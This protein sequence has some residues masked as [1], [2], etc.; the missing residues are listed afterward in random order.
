MVTKTVYRQ[1]RGFVIG[2]LLITFIV[3]ALTFLAI[4]FSYS[5]G[6]SAP[7]ASNPLPLAP[8]ATV[9][10]PDATEVPAQVIPSETPLPTL[11]L[12]T[13]PTAPVL[14]EE[15]TDVPTNTPTPIPSPTPTPLPV[16]DDRYQAGIQVE[17]SLDF[18]PVN[19]DNYYRS[20]AEDLG[21][22]WVKHQVRWELMEPAPGEIDWSVLDF[23]MPSAKKF[24]IKMLLSIVTAPHWAREDGVTLERHGPPADAHVYA[25]FVAAIV[26]RYPGQVHAIEVWNEQNLNREWT[27]TGGL[28]ASNYVSLLS[29]TYQRVKAIDPGIIIISGALSPTG[30]NDGVQAYDDFNYLN[31][32]IEAG[33]L[34]STDCVGAH[35]NGYNVAPEY[36]YNE[37]PDDPGASFRGPFD[38]PHHSWSF[39]ST[40]EGYANR[41]RTAGYATRLCVTE[42]GW[43]SA[44]DLQ[45]V[46]QGFEFA[47]DN[48]L[49]E[50]AE[51]IPRA[52]TL[53]EE[54]GFV[55]LAIVWNFN[56]GPQAGYAIDNDNVPFSLIG[57][58]YIFRPAYDTIRLWQSSYQ[59]RLGD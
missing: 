47:K 10:A 17:H 7:D 23:V 42:F 33:M 21:L 56:Y 14:A 41:I 32:L 52:L 31:Q 49:A 3:G 46:R 4:Y 6:E 25:D 8:S 54:L 58:G 20:V 15:V 43:A 55:W 45:D 9:V 44:E 38:N 22:R 51:W 16:D 57:P 40:L 48:T 2:W 30:W 19:Q 28:N 24:G 37:I 39:R 5:Q 27:S 18:N 12:A 53:M 13:E 26:Q 34:E 59:T 50:Q 29:A 36:R 35:H 11:A 1:L